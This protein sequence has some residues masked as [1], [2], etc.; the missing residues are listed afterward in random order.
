MIID[1]SDLIRA[2]EFVQEVEK[3][4]T[5][6]DKALI[7]AEATKKA[8]NQLSQLNIPITPSRFK[9]WFFAFLILILKGVFNPSEDDILK[10]YL[11]TFNEMKGK[12]D[13]S[14]LEI[15]KSIISKEAEET[16]DMS[17]MALQEAISIVEKHI[18]QLAE[19]ESSLNV[20]KT[21]EELSKT[22]ELLT[23]EIRA[24]QK[25]NMELKEELNKSVRKMEVLKE[26]LK[27][28]QE[29]SQKDPLTNLLNR[30]KFEILLEKYL[31]DLKNGKIKV[32]SIAMLDI[33][34]FKKLND[35]FGHMVGDEFLRRCAGVMIGELRSNDLAFRYGGEE[36]AIIISEARL[37]EAIV[38]CERLRRKIEEIRITTEMG[39]AKTTVSIGIAEAKNDDTVRSIVDRADKALYLAKR[40]GKNCIRT[41]EDVRLRKF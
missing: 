9:V 25:T 20:I 27:A 18:K 40:D 13:F 11:L 24:L 19:R 3:Q 41:E 12:K 15:E 4:V 21:M 14:P 38:V 28:L 31:K 39:V 34:N 1:K 2:M 7:L 30:A 10:A 35:L 29:K 8:L 5:S 32:F 23:Q 37:K 26:R 36:F 17:R 22:I 33:D 6:K 16:L